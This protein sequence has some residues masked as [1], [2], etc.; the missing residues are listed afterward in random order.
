MARW[1]KLVADVRRALASERRN[2][3]AI[4]RELFGGRYALLS[5]ND[6]DLPIL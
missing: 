4:E 2:R 5:K 1:W 3:K 6:D